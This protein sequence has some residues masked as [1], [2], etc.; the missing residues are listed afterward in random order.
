[1]QYNLCSPVTVGNF[2]WRR[3]AISPPSDPLPPPHHSQFH[4]CFVHSRTVLRKMKK[5]TSKSKHKSR[6]RLPR[7]KLQIN[8]SEAPLGIFLRREGP[9]TDGGVGTSNQR[10]WDADKKKWSPINK[11]RLGGARTWNFIIYFN[12][13]P[14]GCHL[15]GEEG[16]G[17]VNETRK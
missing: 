14:T 3:N 7:L 13:H 11:G 10:V 8:Q 6:A 2:V 17:G 5:R 9:P 4:I 12:I 1:M 15:R 16:G